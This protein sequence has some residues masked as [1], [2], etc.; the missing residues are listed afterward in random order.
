MSANALAGEILFKATPVVL[1]R[2]VKHYF[3]KIGAEKKDTKL[4]EEELLY[5]ETFH[6]VKKFLQWASH[7]S[8]EEVQAFSNTRTPSPPWIHVVRTEVPKSCCDEAASILIDVLGGEDHMRKIIGGIK[9]W[10]TRATDGIDAQWITE[11]KD[12]ERHN[13]PGS[14]DSAPADQESNENGEAGYDRS[15]DEQRC[16]L[17]LHGGG[18]YFGSVDQERYCI[19]RH[20]RKVKGRVFAI[21]YR[22][23][24]QYPFPCALQD[25]LAAY[26]YLT[27]PPEGAPHKRV[28]PKHIVISGDS[29]GGGLSL[30]LL[31]VIRDSPRFKDAPAGGVLISPWCD[32]T[33]SFPSISD[34]TG[35][36]V[37]PPWGLSL[38]KPS[39]VWPPPTTSSQSKKQSTRPSHFR[40][41]SRTK[42]NAAEAT[43][44]V[45]EEPLQIPSPGSDE[46]I[47]S[48]DGTALIEN[49]VQL[50]APNSLLIHPLVSGVYSY[51]GGL[52]PLLIIAGDK[53]VLRDEI[54]YLAHKAA[55]PEK[56]KPYKP[57]QQLYPP[58]ANLQQIKPTQVHLQVYDDAAHVLPVL[59]AFTTPAKYC[60][61]AIASFTAHVTGLQLNPWSRGKRNR[62]QRNGTRSTEGSSILSQSSSTQPT[63][64]SPPLVESPPH[65]P[66]RE[67]SVDA[68]LTTKGSRRSGL[69]RAFSERVM[70]RNT[71][72]FS[73]QENGVD[74]AKSNTL[75][76]PDTGDVAGPK[77][78]RYLEEAGQLNTAGDASVYAK[79]DGLMIRERVDIAGNIRPLEPEDELPA[80]NAP[81]LGLIPPKVAQ[82]YIF[83]NNVFRERY[84]RSLRSLSVDDEGKA[85][86]R[87]SMRHR[88]RL[89]RSNAKLVLLTPKEDDQLQSADA[90]KMSAFS[91]SIEEWRN[92]KDRLKERPPACSIMTRETVE[93]AIRLARS[94]DQALLHYPSGNQLWSSF[95][96]FFTFTGPGKAPNATMPDKSAAPAVGLEDNGFLTVEP[97]AIDTSSDTEVPINGGGNLKGTVSSPASTSTSDLTRRGSKFWRWD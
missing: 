86:R 13:K 15:M 65:S 28:D 26:L 48:A 17:Y 31:Q 96:E 36:D 79:W 37:M 84:G 12:W 10:Q 72:P 61:R 95:V 30:S 56:Y 51:L 45:I 52:P 68:T 53:E 76:M 19:Q 43:P 70:Q 80:L 73:A 22:L 60:F 74:V 44:S 50:Y 29:A 6:I 8:V 35:T 62:K 16:I 69:F 66:T 92:Y 23:A 4:H 1:E 87:P 78:G 57:S 34:N 67:L 89:S 24:P 93:E 14:Q 49:Q 33:H 90:S 64:P 54:L 77:F 83:H 91:K 3:D 38:Q 21:N 32:L 59:F 94:A 85:A 40:L 11:M 82:R 25:A 75:P 71:Q 55:N 58:I 97:Q 41:F 81:H 20:A 18:Y 5:D 9:W 39:E 42:I 47:R 7:H 88:F 2:F 27:E 63:V 46:A